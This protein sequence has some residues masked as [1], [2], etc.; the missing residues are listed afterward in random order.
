M[1]SGPTKIIYPED[2]LPVGQNLFAGLQRV[3]AMFGG[4]VLCPLLIEFDPNTTIFFSGLGS[5]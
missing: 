1:P 5:S 4:A 3:L 2:R